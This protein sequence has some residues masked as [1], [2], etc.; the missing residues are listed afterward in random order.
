MSRSSGNKSR[1]LLLCLTLACVI[2]VVDAQTPGASNAH[3]A[4]RLDVQELLAQDVHVST[5]L[6]EGDSFDMLVNDRTGQVKQ[7]RA[8]LVGAF[9]QRWGRLFQMSTSGAILKATS[10]RSRVCGTAI[11]RN[12]LHHAFQDA[13]FTI[14]F[15]LASDIDPTLRELPPPGLVGGG[16]PKASPG[17]IDPLTQPVSIVTGGDTLEASLNGLVAAAP[18]LGWYASE[19]CDQTGRCGCYVGLITPTAVLQPGYD[20]NAGRR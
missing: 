13:P 20:A 16:G 18:T 4:L 5:I 17:Y 9:T 8:A 1:W 10:V 2:S 6:G 19:Q 12:V 14:L 3:R 7:D 11:A 15:N